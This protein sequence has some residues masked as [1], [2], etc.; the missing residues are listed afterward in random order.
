MIFY[1]YQQT[2]KATLVDEVIVATDDERI[3][4]A[5]VDFGGRVLMTSEQHKTGTDR[6]AEVASY[7]E[8]DIFVNVQGDEPGIHPDSIDAVIDPLLREP[9][10]YVTNLMFPIRDPAD[11]V[12]TTVV[13]VVKDLSD[14]FLFLTRA[15]VPYPKAREGYYPYRQLGVYAFRRD[16]LL[17]FAQMSQTPL[18][19]VEG[20]EF[21]R[22]LEHGY[23]VKGVLSPGV[24]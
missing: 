18:E 20:I 6:V 21:M 4:D 16:F 3:R 11:L 19:L 23:R 5:V 22:I 12:D 9:D 1:V 2:T 10:L 15:P 7:I 24:A 14:F 13:K 17:K 8:A